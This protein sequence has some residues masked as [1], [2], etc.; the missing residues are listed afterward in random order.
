MTTVIRSQEPLNWQLAP[1]AFTLAVILFLMAC[2][3][4]VLG[5]FYP[6]AKLV[7][8][9]FC[10][11]SLFCFGL[12]DTLTSHINEGLFKIFRLAIGSVIAML[13]WIH[14]IFPLL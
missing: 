1:V 4:L 9:V 12:T 14:W 11:V 3:L 13:A 10:L 6:A 5:Y 2:P 8:S 7:S